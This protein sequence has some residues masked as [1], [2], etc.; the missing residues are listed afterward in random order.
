M[1][2]CIPTGMGGEPGG[3][4]TGG[5]GVW[6]EPFTQLCVNGEIKT[7]CI[8]AL[9]GVPE[10]TCH[11]QVHITTVGGVGGGGTV[12]EVEPLCRV[13]VAPRSVQSSLGF[14]LVAATLE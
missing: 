12:E 14:I 8:T 10:A 13:V 9:G 2:I 3:G 7:Q 11:S 5:L 4:S 6:G 1:T